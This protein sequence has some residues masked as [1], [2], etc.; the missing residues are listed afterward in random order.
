[1]GCSENIIEA[2]WLALWVSLGAAPSQER[3]SSANTSADSAG[4]SRCSRAETEV[5]PPP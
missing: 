3:R 5:P 4:M 2:S 1:M